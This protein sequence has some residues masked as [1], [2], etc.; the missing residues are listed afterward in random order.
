MLFRSELNDPATEKNGRQGKA[1][2]GVD[3]YGRRNCKHW[4]GVQCKQKMDEAVSEAE[5]REEVD[6]AKS[7]SP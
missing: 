3:V 1:Q 2:H 5:L 6:K 7:F 4:V